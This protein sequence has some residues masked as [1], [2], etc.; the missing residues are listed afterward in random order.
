MG[1]VVCVANQKGGVAKTTTV[2]NLGSYLAKREKKI[3]IVDF[4]PQAAATL[5]FGFEPLKLEKT[6][7]HVLI[8][9]EN[10]ENIILKTE[11]ED[12]FLA[13]SNIHLSGAEIELVSMISRETILKEKIDA[14]KNKY[15][16]IFIDTPP[17]LGL[18]T[19]NALVAA[20]SVLIPIQCEYYALEGIGHLLRLLDLLRKRLRKSLPIE[21]VLLT[22]YDSRTKLSSEVVEQVRDFFKD[23]VFNTVIP[24]NV[25]LAESPS[26]G[27]P[28]LL[29]DPNS[30]GAEAYDKLAE[31]FLEKE[32][33]KA[34]V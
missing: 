11:V 26:F 10:I 30:R 27:K 21:G 9:R 18:L 17:S 4:D 8:G 6:I 33:V 14:V 19:V 20:D 3:L 16:Y 25:R 31:E 15:D 28:I 29:Y 22:M 2:V 1:K 23:K 34:Y 13:P 7:Y 32:G 12:L 24:R 5:A